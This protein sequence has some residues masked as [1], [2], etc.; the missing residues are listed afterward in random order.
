ESSLIP[1]SSTCSTILGFMANLLAIYALYSARSIMV[2]FALVAQ[3]DLIFSGGGGN[4][5]GSAA[6]NSVMHASADGD[7]GIYKVQQKGRPG[8]S[9]SSSFPRLLIL[10]S[11]HSSSSSSDQMAHYQLS[12]SVHLE[13]GQQDPRI[14]SGSKFTM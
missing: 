7:R 13:D 3:S 4:D 14:S 1:N 9:G 11:Q 5:E 8:A 6:A 10:S 2:K 12:P